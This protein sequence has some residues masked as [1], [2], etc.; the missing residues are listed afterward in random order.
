MKIDVLRINWIGMVAATV[1]VISL[2]FPWWSLTRDGVIVSLYLWGIRTSPGTALTIPIN[3]LYVFLLVPVT[4]SIALGILGSVE[5]RYFTIGG[6]ILN[7]LT[8]ALFYLAFDPYWIS[9][10]VTGLRWGLNLGFYLCFIAGIL[11]IVA[12]IIHPLLVKILLRRR[13]VN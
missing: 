8:V 1:T 2:I 10:T 11:G 7:L 5:K 6:G 4:T 13:Y 9:G 12:Y 3:S